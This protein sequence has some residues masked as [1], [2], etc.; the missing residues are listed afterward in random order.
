MLF[1]TTDFAI[2]FVIVFLASWLLQPTPLRWK[3]FMVVASYFFYGW[4]NWH[5]IFL[6]AGAT[7]VSQVGAQLTYRARS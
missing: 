3:C 2:F 1:P 6:L 4:W 7:A 5:F